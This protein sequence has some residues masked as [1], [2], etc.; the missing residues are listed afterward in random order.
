[1]AASVARKAFKL[2]DIVD[3]LLRAGS[4]RF[5]DI[6][7]GVEIEV[8]GKIPDDRSSLPDDFASVGLELSGQNSKKRRLAC[9]I[10]SDQADAIAGAKRE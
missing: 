10:S 3:D 7:A 5:I 1:M 9:A 8:L 6:G 4:N 2:R